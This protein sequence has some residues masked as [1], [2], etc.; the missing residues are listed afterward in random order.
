MASDIGSRSNDRGATVPEG[1]VTTHMQR[2]KGEL[3]AREAPGVRQVVD[4]LT[5]TADAGR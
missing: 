5:V 2:D 4:T 1:D 3:L